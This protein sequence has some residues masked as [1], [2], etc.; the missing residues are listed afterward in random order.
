MDLTMNDPYLIW[1][2][3]RIIVAALA[4]WVAAV[5]FKITWWRWKDDRANIDRD[6]PHPALYASYG[7]CLV[8]LALDRLTHILDRLV[9]SYAVVGLALF[10]LGQRYR[11]GWSLLRGGKRKARERREKRRR[12]KQSTG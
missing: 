10:G 7:V 8:L 9:A 11:F 5:V 12:R 2:I 1:D 3:L 6:R 4:I